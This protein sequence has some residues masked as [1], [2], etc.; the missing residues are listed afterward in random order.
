MNPPCLMSTLAC[1]FPRRVSRLAL[2]LHAGAVA[3]D[4]LPHG[5]LSSHAPERPLDVL[6]LVTTPKLVAVVGAQHTLVVV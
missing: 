2:L 6:A 3:A 4:D 5:A 1:V